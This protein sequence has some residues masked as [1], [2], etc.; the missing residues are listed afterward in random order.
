LPAHYNDYA[1]HGLIEFDISSFPAGTPVNSATLG[2]KEYYLCDSN[3]FFNMRQN[4]ERKRNM[5]KEKS[6]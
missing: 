4:Q 2:L 6:V 3:F 5:K 1:T